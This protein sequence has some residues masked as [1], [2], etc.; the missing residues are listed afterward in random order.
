MLNNELFFSVRTSFLAAIKSLS[1]FL[2]LIISLFIDSRLLGGICSSK[3]LLQNGHILF[4]ELLLKI[5]SL[6]TIKD[7][8]LISD[9]YCDSKAVYLFNKISHSARDSFV[10]LIES[11]I[12]FPFVIDSSILLWIIF[13]S[14]VSWFMLSQISISS[15]KMLLFCFIW[16][17]LFSISFILLDIYSLSADFFALLMLSFSS[18]S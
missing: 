16:L 13:N 12:F 1:W 9:K 18:G 15:F 3:W 6:S 11:S 7:N 5:D 8:R 14:Q 17:I 10:E 2:I 4:V